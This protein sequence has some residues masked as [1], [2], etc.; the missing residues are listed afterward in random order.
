MR[1]HLDFGA[2]HDNFAE[3]SHLREASGRDWELGDSVSRW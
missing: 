2:I 3:F 1:G